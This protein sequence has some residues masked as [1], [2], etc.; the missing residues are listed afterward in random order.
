M[1]EKDLEAI[2]ELIMHSGEGKS[3]AIEAIHAAKTGDFKLAEEK[4]KAAEKSLS[5]AHH[6]QSDMLTQEARGEHRDITILLIHGQ[7]H[8]MTGIAFKD[9]AKEMVEL[10]KVISVK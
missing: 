7:D 4:I 3:N 8:L 9:I 2:M 6:A 5:Q 10:Y 1:D